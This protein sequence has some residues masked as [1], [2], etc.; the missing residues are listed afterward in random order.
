M[1]ASDLTVVKIQVKAAKCAI[2]SEI[3]LATIL[4]RRMQCARN[5]MSPRQL[6]FTGMGKINIFL[7]LLTSI[8]LLDVVSPVTSN[9]VIIF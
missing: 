7:L 3:Y 1:P 6:Y 2:L 8:F 5:L 9:L 4:V